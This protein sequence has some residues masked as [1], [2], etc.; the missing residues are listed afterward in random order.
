MDNIDNNQDNLQ[1]SPEIN[2]I[3]I[4]KF[5]KADPNSEKTWREFTR[6]LQTTIQQVKLVQTSLPKIAFRRQV[7]Y[8]LLA[9]FLGLAL[10]IILPHYLPKL[11]FKSVT[12][13]V[14]MAPEA[15]LIVFAWG[16]NSKEFLSCLNN[17]TTN[18][19]C[20]VKF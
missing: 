14:A 7:K 5:S 12:G 4:K 19:T 20:A 18:K 2:R 8:C 11:G 13:G 1:S 6:A 16:G 3:S 9:L 15:G 10:G 17:P